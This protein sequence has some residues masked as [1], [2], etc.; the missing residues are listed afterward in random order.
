MT[1]G[2]AEASRSRQHKPAGAI[3]S[4]HPDCGG[5]LP[6][7]DDAE[8]P[9]Y[10]EERK[11]K[12]VRCPPRLVNSYQDLAGDGR[13]VNVTDMTTRYNGMFIGH[14]GLIASSA[15]FAA[16]IEALMGGL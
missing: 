3:W 9:E 8:I 2:P 1:R 7:P 6:V 10:D 4:H 13:L 12:N 16:F 5:R 14:T 15:D 11:A